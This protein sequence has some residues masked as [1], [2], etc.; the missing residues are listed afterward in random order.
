MRNITT[1]VLLVTAL[2]SLSQESTLVYRNSFDSQKSLNDWVMEGP[3]N[4]K[5]EDG[6]LFIHSKWSDELNKLK[7]ENDTTNNG[8]YYPFL[9]NLVKKYE[10]EN[11]SRYV[12]KHHVPGKF[13]GGHIQYWNKN[14]HPEN[15]LIRIKFQA[16]SVHPLHMVTFCA[17]GKNGENVLDSKLEP[18]YG[19]AAQ[20]MYGDI[21]NYRI[22]Y[23]GGERGT[24]NMRKAPG[25]KL[26]TSEKE[27][28]PLEALEREVQL[29]VFRW[30]G[31]VIF[32]C[33][34][35]ILVDW[36]D[37][38]PFGDGFFSLRLMATAKGWYDDYEVYE[39]HENPFSSFV[40]GE[41]NIKNKAIHPEWRTEF[42]P[43]RSVA[44][45]N[46]PVLIAPTERKDFEKSFMLHDFQLSRDVSFNNLFAEVYD[47]KA[48]FFIPPEPLGNGQWYWRMR[49]NMGKWTGPFEFTVNEKVWVNAAPPA[50]LFVEGVTIDR[51]R[52]LARKT[53][54]KALRKEQEQTELYR[55]IIK[56]AN[57]Y[58]GVELPEKEY[59]GKFYKKGKRILQNRKFPPD[60]SKS[61]PTGRIF[62][63][64]CHTLSL[65]YILSGDKVYGQEA[66]RWAMQVASFEI[67]PGKLAGSQRYHDNFD[68]S[69]Q[70]SALTYAYDSA[71]E[72]MTELQRKVILKSLRERSSSFYS[73]FVNRLESRVMDNHAWQHT[74]HMFLEAAIALKGDVTEADDYLAY[75]YEVWRARQPIQSTFDGG[76]NNGKYYGV[77]METWMNVP[78]HFQKFT[79]FN[80]YN[81]PWYKNHIEW[82][83]YRRPPGSNG[84][85]FAG[86]GYE[87]PTVGLNEKEACWVNLLSAEFDSDLGSWMAGTSNKKSGKYKSMPW[88]RIAEGLPLNLG[89]PIRKP[90][91]IAQSKLFPDVGI[92][93]MNRNILNAKEN[94]MVSMR[95]APWGG[96]GHNHPN[97][98]AFSVVY[99]GKSLF[100]PF[101]H[102]DAGKEHVYKCYRH[103]RGYNTVLVNGKGQPLS[104]EAFG[105]IPRFLDGEKITY[106]CGDA[107]KAYAGTPSP[108]WFERVKTSGVEWDEQYGADELKRFRR[109]LV[110]LKPSLVVV[111]DEL[112]ASEPVR[113]DWLLHCRKTLEAKGNTLV[114]DDTARVQFFANLPLEF[115]IRDKELIKPFNVSGRGGNPPD[116]YGS[117]GTH[118]YVTP[119]EKSNALRIVSLMQLG[120]FFPV[121]KGNDGSLTC[122]E[123]TIK[124]ELDPNKQAQMTVCNADGSNK[125]TLNDGKYGASVIEEI[126]DGK[127]VSK[128]MVD[129]VPLV[130]NSLK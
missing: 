26:V 54:I 123:W 23:W 78:I 120:E 69:A 8:N 111:Y 87:L 90:V 9:E 21:Q 83:L 95:S 71:Y 40:N 106:A 42:S 65:A 105:W 44:L 25:R 52:V 103:T 49:K 99:M 112:E 11:L 88:Q 56:D 60:H 76:W 115:D 28:V 16:A 73:Y 3:G 7:N 19:L 46:P 4:A 126:I 101:R 98:N 59:G 121:V 66:V 68:W 27:V 110:F 10:P 128:S 38:E 84:D 85:G 12:L 104:S 35:E 89:K 113:W 127:L 116:V 81:H 118:A 93:N 96:F 107:S 18:R 72:L 14:V 1:L 125:F 62:A 43:N 20:Y 50:K 92:V 124:V 5:V 70:M 51:P 55:D 122:G 30:K 53:R 57:N 22:S 39:L 15:F 37:K 108:Q 67:L 63:K 74:F 117:V 48:S 36:S 13:A 94:L 114:V 2:R 129:E 100:V 58:I 6:R 31:R 75:C 109:H 102:K 97:H 24:T 86:D 119:K 45:A 32:K 91:E 29:E 82:I 77:N 61:Q 47:R 33:D 34:G 41:K 17:R 79:G 130:V 80:F 64:A